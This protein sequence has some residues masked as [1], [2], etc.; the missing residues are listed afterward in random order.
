MA[1]ERIR[2]G[3][4]PS[5]ASLVVGGAVA[6]GVVLQ[7]FSA[8]DLWRDEVLSVNIAR[9]PLGDL[10]EALRHDG[11]PPLYYLVLHGWMEVVGEGDRAVR[12]LSALFAI[13]SLPLLW[14]IGSQ[15]GGR[16]SMVAKAAIVLAATSPHLVR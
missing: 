5:L 10:G 4:R 1:A 9:L 14:V 11:S 12:A 15:I 3:S 7:L 16:R 8:S 2:T 13:G 6:A